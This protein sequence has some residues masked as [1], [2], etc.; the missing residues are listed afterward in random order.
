MHTTIEHVSGFILAGGKS[1]RMG[2]NKALMKLGDITIIQKILSVLKTV[3]SEV[4]IITNEPKLFEDLNVPMFQ[5][6]V[7]KGPL[8]G[9]HSALTHSRT[10]KIFV[11]A[12]DT[13]FLTNSLIYHI[14]EN[15]ID[16]KIV[17]P[18]ADGYLQHLVAIY[19]KSVLPE[20]ESRLLSNNDIKEK[21]CKMSSLFESVKGKTIYV[22]KEFPEYEPK[23]FWNINTREEYQ[24]ITNS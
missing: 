21:A 23:L 12:C 18:Y 6:L 9:I 5:D 24:R 7:G 16:S 22:E 3:F 13:P 14:I 10:E 4:S 19:S 8:S 11:C 17:V 20:I 15:S 2:E 1:S